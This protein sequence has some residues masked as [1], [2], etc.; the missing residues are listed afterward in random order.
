MTNCT[1]RHCGSV[2]VKLCDIICRT[3]D[4]FNVL[5]HWNEQIPPLAFFLWQSCLE[6]H[7][8]I[9]LEKVN[10]RLHVQ[11]PLCAYGLSG[12]ILPNKRIS[13]RKAW[14]K[15]LTQLHKGCFFTGSQLESLN[16]FLY[17]NFWT[18]LLVLN[19]L[20]NTRTRKC[21]RRLS[22]NFRATTF[23]AKHQ[24]FDFGT[25]TQFKPSQA[26]IGS[27]K[28]PEDDGVCCFGS[29]FKATK[30]IDVGPKRGQMGSLNMEIRGTP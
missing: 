16:V 4:C 15:G 24:L 10:L 6:L 28:L 21:E 14:T 12:W 13:E 11:K 8:N 9:V 26:L 30:L 18:G 1:P 25:K 27:S 23:S 7:S 20:A 2:Q 19:G 29:P 3:I 5:S 17:M 22:C